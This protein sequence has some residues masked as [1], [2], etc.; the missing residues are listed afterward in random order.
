VISK[1]SGPQSSYREHLIAVP[2]VP[3]VALAPVIT[4]SIAR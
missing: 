2:A 3:L 1:S 4:R